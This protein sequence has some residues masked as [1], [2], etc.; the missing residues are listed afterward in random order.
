MYQHTPVLFQEVIRGLNPQPGQRFLDGTV[1]GGGHATGI[2]EA[3]APDGRL[4]AFDRDAAALAAARR[5]LKRFAPRVTFVHASYSTLGGEVVRRAFVPLAGVLLDLGLSSAQLDD[6]TR[7]FSFQTP[8]PLDLRFDTEQPATAA[9]LLNTATERELTRILRD[10]GDEP[11]A[12]P[13]ARA[14]VVARRRHPLRTTDDLMS[15][16]MEVKGGF[17]RRSLHPATLVWQALRMAV[18]RELDELECG[19]AAAAAAL[20]PGG[21][22]AVI[23]FHSGEDRL[24]KEFF[25]RESRSCLCPPEFPQCRCGH[26]ATFRRLGA[27]VRATPA[28]VRQ[29]P[30]ARSA[31]LRLAEKIQP[32]I[33]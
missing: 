20:A 4:L 31:T 11:K 12:A 15:I 13:L 26:R 7:G 30:R 14:I 29:N 5:N 3:T 2:L 1:G 21:R 8:G 28:E 18:N 25:R 6:P 10:Y 33:S 16:V 22:L 24:V 9:H 23:S 17:R 27:A 19:L 32:K